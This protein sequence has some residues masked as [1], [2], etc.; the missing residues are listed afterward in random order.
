MNFS[1]KNPKKQNNSDLYMVYVNV[2]LYACREYRGRIHFCDLVAFGH[3]PFLNIVLLW[4]QFSG[5]KQIDMF[6]I[7][8][9]Y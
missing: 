7:S 3:D 6:C 1:P 9:G 4:V 8:I 5:L 2:L